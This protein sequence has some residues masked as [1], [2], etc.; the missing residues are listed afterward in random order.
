MDIIKKAQKIIDIC[1]DHDKKVEKVF[2]NIDGYAPSVLVIFED[3]THT[4]ITGKFAFDLIDI[5]PEP[6]P[7]NV[8]LQEAIEELEKI[9]K[10][11]PHFSDYNSFATKI[12]WILK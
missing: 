2:K 5:N 7:W 4:I 8:K 1:F 6:V 10:Y 12:L 9:Q 11:N 3:E